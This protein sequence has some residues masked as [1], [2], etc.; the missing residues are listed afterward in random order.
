MLHKIHG[1]NPRFGPMCLS[2]IDI[3][4]GFHR[5][6]LCPGDA[7]RLAVLFP[8]CPGEEPPVGIP[9]TLPMGWA[10][11]PPAFCAATE[12]AAD[13]A[14][15]MMDRCQNP[16]TDMPHRLDQLSESPKP[17]PKGANGKVTGPPRRP[18][19]LPTPITDD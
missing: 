1:A 11:S 3:F 13:L 6:G 4:D 2:K 9:L 7:I 8:N 19:H 10:E 15:W 14:N 12:T 17:E 18:T 16:L 5:M